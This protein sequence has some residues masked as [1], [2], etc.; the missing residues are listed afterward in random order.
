[1]TPED[2]QPGAEPVVVLSYRLWRDKRGANQATVGRSLLVD[3]KRYTVIGI[4]PAEFQFAPSW[5]TKAALWTP[6]VLEPRCLDRAGRSLRVFGRLND[7]VNPRTAQAEIDGICARLALEYP[8]TNAKLTATV[9]PLREKVTGAV[10]PTLIA[11]LGVVGFVL[12][13][14][15]ANMANLML[16]RSTARHREI[17]VRAALGASRIRIIRLLLTESAAPAVGGGRAGLVLAASGVQLLL[18]IRPQKLCRG[19]SK[20]T[21]MGLR[22]HWRF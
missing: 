9:I 11:L 15:C 22:S 17:A 18:G 20:S 10:R 4:I 19:R 8:K 2:S 21:L 13:I 1:M 7:G 6:L 14:A 12:A 16:A 3:G 5:M